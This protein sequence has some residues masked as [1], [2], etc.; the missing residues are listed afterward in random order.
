VIDLPLLSAGGKPNT[1]DAAFNTLRGPGFE[2]RHAG[3]PDR[4]SRPGAVGLRA[5]GEHEVHGLGVRVRI[6]RDEEVWFET[7]GKPP[8]PPAAS[9]ETTPAA[10][11]PATTSSA[12]DPAA[13]SGAG[14][15]EKRP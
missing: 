7:L 2:I 4:L 3:E 10:D 11:V 8:A 15:A 1:G 6:E 12:N 5:I 14:A 13:A 9:R